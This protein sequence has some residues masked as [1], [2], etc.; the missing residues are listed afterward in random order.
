MV[1]V[2]LRNCLAD[3]SHQI[4]SHLAKCPYCEVQVH[5]Q[6][7]QAGGP[8]PARSTAWAKTTPTRG[9]THGS[10]TRPVPTRTP[11]SAPTTAFNPAA[12]AG[13][14][15]TITKAGNG[16]RRGN[17]SRLAIGGVVVGLAIL[18][19]FWG[20]SAFE[21]WRQERGLAA[22][23]LGRPDLQDCINSN[24]M[25][26]N[27]YNSSE[28]MTID[29]RPTRVS[30]GPTGSNCEQL[31]LWFGDVLRSQV[32]IGNTEQGFIFALRDQDDP[33]FTLLS[34]SHDSLLHATS[35]DLLQGE[36]EPLWE[37]DIGDVFFYREGFNSIPCSPPYRTDGGMECS[38]QVAVTG[39][40]TVFW[41]SKFEPTRF[42]DFNSSPNAVRFSEVSFANIGDGELRGTF[43]CL[44]QIQELTWAI[45]DAD[46]ILAR[47]L[48]RDA[49]DNAQYFFAEADGSLVR[50]D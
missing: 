22:S 40:E 27:Y 42:P 46:E 10:A 49:E 31:G 41:I 23:A 25:T 18:A 8:T 43:R 26:V 4:P 7:A 15:R 11:A 19:G 44:D 2:G 12:G 36:L 45:N 13:P 14:P 32:Q 34:V 39:T 28:T 50:D 17:P 24:F 38:P 16:A 1:S 48:C 47:L 37:R 3:S 20:V 9:Q 5:R 6:N 29:G 30:V 21:S 35:V 33:H